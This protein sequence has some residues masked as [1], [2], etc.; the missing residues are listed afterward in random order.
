[1]TAVFL[2]GAAFLATAGF[3][4]ADFCAGILRAGTVVRLCSSDRTRSGRRRQAAAASRMHPAPG[5]THGT[6]PNQLC[7]GCE[8][9]RVW[10]GA[11][12]DP[13]AVR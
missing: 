9:A 12:V 11:R 2:A 4:M 5:F 7:L 13:G 10:Q 6:P 1:L 3:F 8:R